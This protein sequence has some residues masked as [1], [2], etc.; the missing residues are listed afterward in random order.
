MTSRPI[1]G[2]TASVKRK[3]PIA[4]DAKVGIKL[5]LGEIVETGP[6]H[7]ARVVAQHTLEEALK[8]TH[9]KGSPPK[10]RRTVGK[11]R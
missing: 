4:S 3:V 2:R 6:G 11:L 8:K 1:E 7:T 10:P 9:R 5:V